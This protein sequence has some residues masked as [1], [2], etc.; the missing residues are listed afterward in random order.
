[1]GG[2]M[3]KF[4]SVILTV[5]IIFCSLAVFASAK[6]EDVVNIYICARSTASPLGHLWVYFE[7]LT[8][9]TVMVGDYALPAKQ[10]VSVGT[11]GTKGKDGAGVY[12][13]VEAYSAGHYGISGIISAKDGLT[14][15]ELEKVSR[16]ITDSDIWTP[17][18]CNCMGFAF[19]VWDECCRPALIPLVFPFIGRL[20]MLIFLGAS[21]DL[22]MYIPNADQVYR[23][24]KGKGIK[25][26]SDGMLK[27]VL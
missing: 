11:W 10:G 19:T 2:I 9:K 20:E 12:Y 18:F 6:D 5:C 4:I 7:N 14:A 15:E 21:R 8:D 13:N 3:K 26:V 22:Q 24:V 16:E 23:Q 1:M 17:F 25:P 27:K